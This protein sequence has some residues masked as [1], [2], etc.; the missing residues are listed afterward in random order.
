MK[1]FKKDK[2]QISNIS[3][4]F[5]V[6]GIFQKLNIYRKRQ[7]IL[8]ILLMLFSAFSE[9]FSLALII[10]F[11]SL[12]TSSDNLLDNNLIKIIAQ[13]LNINSTDQLILPITFIF[14]FSILISSFIKL[15]TLFL[16]HRLSARIGSDISSKGLSQIIYQPFEW[17]IDKNSSELIVALTNSINKTVNF[18]RDSLQIIIS[19]LII[20]VMSLSLYLIEP[21]IFLIAFFII[22][23]SYFLV[24]IN[25]KNKLE[26]YSKIIKQRSIKQV[27]ATQEAIA[28]LVNIK[29]DKTYEKFID[30]YN[31]VEIPLRRIIANSTFLAQFPKLLI[32]ALSLI[33]LIL[34]SYL[35]LITSSNVNILQK[36]GILAFAAQKMLPE[37][38]KI[39]A[40]W[41]NLKTNK[42][43]VIQVL[44][45]LNQPLKAYNIKK[46]L[47]PYNPKIISLKNISYSY[48][49]SNINI[50]KNLNL[51]IEIGEKIGIVGKTGTGKSTFLNLF[52]GLLRPNSGKFL[53]DEK[54]ISIKKNNVLLE[55][56]Q[57]SISYI[58]QDFYIKDGSIIENIAYGQKKEEFDYEKA[59]WAI[60][61]AQMSDFIIKSKVGLNASVGERG[62]KLSGGQKQRLIIARALYKNT[63]IMI[64]DEATSALDAVTEKKLIEKL[65]QI[66]CTGIIVSHRS[67]SL[68]YCDRIIEINP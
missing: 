9:V 41:A 17:H 54:D 46:D 52:M 24:I 40:S 35:L 14:I 55:R 59:Y 56:F 5:L 31:S 60:E 7:L 38:Q 12:L 28:S 53:L 49:N 15:F 43:L 48:P 30:D 57:L 8:L 47:I 1:K 51:D 11:I 29:L 62:K 10:P 2:Y 6:K 20:F 26:K 63:D 33:L 65:C 44:S 61:I 37:F 34:L 27:Q 18:V 25:I 19:A 3:L 13:T 32:E 21:E 66:K 68:K 58:P 42:S 67:A 45:I 22:I 23:F 36:I 16:S 50:I 39:F 4:L 64:L